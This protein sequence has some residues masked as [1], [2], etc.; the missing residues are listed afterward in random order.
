MRLAHGL[1]IRFVVIA[2]VCLW[3]SSAWVLIDI[4][5]SLR[6]GARRAA[7]SVARQL[8][9]QLSMTGAGQAGDVR[10]PVLKPVL[11]DGLA[12]GLC[13]RYRT[14]GGG[15]AQS[16]CKGS[17]RLDAAPGWFGALYARLFDPSHALS[18]PIEFRGDVLGAVD[19][20]ADPEATIA[21]AWSRLRVVAAVT[22]ATVGAA[23]LLVMLAIGEALRPSRAVLAGLRRMAQGDLATRLPGFRI[24]EFRTIAVAFNGLAERLQRVEDERSALT[25]RLFQ[26]QEEERRHLARELHDAFGQNLAAI[27]ALAAALEMAPPDGAGVD[28][29]RAIGRIVGDMMAS[30]RT[31]LGQLRPPELDELGLAA[32]LRGLV[33]GWNASSG[34][35]TTF[36]LET[37]G[38]LDDLPPA[39]ALSV[40]RI[41]QEGLT[42]A[43]RH[44]HARRVEARLV[45]GPADAGCGD[46]MAI[47]VED[48][49]GAPAVPALAGAGL[50]IL[51][52]KERVAALGGRLTLERT[53]RGFRL[54]AILPIPVA[55]GPGGEVG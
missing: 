19:I 12:P 48:D 35:Q 37:L 51:G 1:M 53:G 20:T 43:A 44:A 36:G 8:E 47:R 46:Q 5:R 41:A 54:T 9:L 33:A 26:V 15:S 10:F 16:F 28:D 38:D 31:S 24:L 55:D 2:L 4:D 23:T 49:G 40:Y 30:L 39:A 27:G 34:G 32:S 52:I 18:W 11:D 25:R 22:V 42:N 29:A 50:G 13:V 7:V 45:R 6:D 3:A 14:E 17:G 21:T